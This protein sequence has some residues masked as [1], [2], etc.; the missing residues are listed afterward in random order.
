VIV[1]ENIFSKKN[2]LLCYMVLLK[3][4]IMKTVQEIKNRKVPFVT[5]DPSLNKLKEQNLS[6]KK[7]VKAK[8]MLKTAKLPTKK[9]LKS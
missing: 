4:S 5:I 3:L 2:H 7:W 9:E 6:P 8:M 1:G